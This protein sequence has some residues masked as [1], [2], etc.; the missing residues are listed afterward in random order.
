MILYIFQL[1]TDLARTTDK[2][3]EERTK[4]SLRESSRGMHASELDDDYGR[5]EYEVTKYSNTSIITI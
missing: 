5:G 3:K 4:R 2:L 1:K